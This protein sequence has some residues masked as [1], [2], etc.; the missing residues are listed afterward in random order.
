MMSGRILDDDELRAELEDAYT[1][2]P[3]ATRLSTHP[4]P[5]QGAV[6]RHGSK[7]K[8]STSAPIAEASG[9]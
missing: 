8:W 5:S 3:A 4:I 7:R 1:L 2:V 9:G 6:G